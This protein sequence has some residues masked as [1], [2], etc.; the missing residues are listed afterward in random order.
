M[1]QERRTTIQGFVGI[2]V[3]FG[4]IFVSKFGNMYFTSHWTNPSWYA[5]K[6]IT[7]GVT[8]LIFVCLV[9]FAK[10]GK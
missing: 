2:T 7:W 5:F 8:A 1:S 4:A 10:E 3:L 6:G 9:W